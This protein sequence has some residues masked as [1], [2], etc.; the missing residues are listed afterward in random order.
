M[1]SIG[2]E[3]FGIFCDS[4]APLP[5]SELAFLFASPAEHTRATQAELEEALGDSDE[6]CQCRDSFPISKLQPINT[7]ESACPECHREIMRDFRACDE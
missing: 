2:K 1:T 5:K 7:K 6:C 4:H 3:L